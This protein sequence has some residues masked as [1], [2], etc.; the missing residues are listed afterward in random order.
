MLRK[1]QLEPANQLSLVTTYGLT[2]VLAAIVFAVLT[3]VGGD[4]ERLLPG[5]DEVDLALYLNALTFLVAAVVIWNLPSISGRRAAGAAEPQESFFGSLKHGL[6]L[7]RPHPAGP[8]PGRRHHRRLRGGRRDHRDRAGV[9]RT[10][11]AAATPPTACSSA[12]SSSASA[13]ASRSARASP[14]TSPASASS[15]SRS[16]APASMVLLMSWTF[17]LWIALLLVVLM[18]FFAGIA[19]LA[20]FTLL[21]TE[22]ED[23]IRGRTFAIVQSLVRAALIL[24][25]AVVP[26][27]VGLSASTSS[28]SAPFTRPGHRRADHAAR[29][30]AAGRRRRASSPTG[31]WTTAGRCRCSPTSSPRCAATP[32]PGAGW[33]AAGSSS[34]SRAARAPASPPR[35]AGCRSG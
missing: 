5:V 15:A 13:W 11:S 28:T 25:L 26:F 8:R 32:P 1:D 7:R 17:T 33:P 3:T 14:A 18:G 16:S 20:G 29:R 30:R 31:R 12:R 22:V 35:C 19:Y 4:L 24:S 9:R 23:E 34:P 27:G 2:P 6:L 10:R 21:G